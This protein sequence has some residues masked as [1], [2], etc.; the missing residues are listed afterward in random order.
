M[1]LSPNPETSM[2]SPIQPAGRFA[3]DHAR[4]G[5]FVRIVR[6]QGSNAGKF[7]R[8]TVWKLRHQ[9]QSSTHRPDV[10]TQCGYQQ[11]GALFYSGHVLLVGA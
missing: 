8:R 10:A 3:T 4:S 11:V 9:A 1:S 6:V 7:D 5:T 2:Q